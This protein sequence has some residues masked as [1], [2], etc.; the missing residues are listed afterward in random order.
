MRRSNFV[1]KLVSVV[2]FIAI[3]CYVALH[4]FISQVNPLKTA[5]AAPGTVEYRTSVSG[6]VMRNESVLHSS[7][8]ISLLVE[9]GRKIPAG[10]PIAVEYKSDSALERAAEIRTVELEISQLEKALFASASKDSAYDATFALSGAIA[11]HSFSDLDKYLMNVKSTVFLHASSDSTEQAEQLESL[12]ATLTSLKESANGTEFI[13]SPGSGIFCTGSDGLESITPGDIA[14]M[15][16]S[17]LRATFVGSNNPA[18]LGTLVSGLE[19]YYAA[20]MPSADAERLTIGESENF[21]FDNVGI[22]SMT[23]ESISAA[24]NGECTVLFSSSK[25]LADFLH[26]RALDADIIF[27]SHSGIRILKEAVSYDAAGKPLV[28]ILSG[29][30]AELVYVNILGEH[31][32]AYIVEDGVENDTPLR[33]GSEIIVKAKDLY[34]GKVITS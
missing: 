14:E 18:A 3:A 19:W 33:I 32:D 29:I 21:E 13:Y 28:Y 17:A 25:N 24:E 1:I 2:I 9:D 4:I 27:E 11:K 26:A 31:E 16:P 23:A 10:A 15:P 7:T 12:R 5:L 20:I 30:Q 6:F 34:D 22:I 8:N